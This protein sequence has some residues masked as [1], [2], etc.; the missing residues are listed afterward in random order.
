MSL[1]LKVYHLIENEQSRS[2]ASRYLN[3]FLIVLIISNVTA[4]IFESEA[5]IRAAYGRFFFM[6]ELVSV[7]IFLVEYLARVWCCVE[8]PELKEHAT[9]RA[10]L[11]YVIKP[12]AIIDLMAI[13]PFL[14][15]LFFTVDL[16]YLRLFRVLRLMKLTH[17][18]KGFNIFMT[19]LQKE[20][21]S[22]A[23]AM[24]MMMFLIVIAASVM[25]A[26]E[27]K[28]QPEQFG[29][30]LHSLWWAVVTMTTVGYGDVT[31]LTTGGRIVATFIMIIGVGFVALPAGMLAGRFGEELR[32]RKLDLEVHIEQALADGQI[33]PSEYKTLQELADKLD[34][35]TED[36]EKNISL[37]KKE[38]LVGRCPLCGR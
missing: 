14:I 19:V 18:F 26:L 32:E 38:K 23:A 34:L 33:D 22:I 9:W 37:L 15:S 31:P 3:L 24:M 5:S 36:L 11:R 28:T 29:S 10:R 27:S 8:R 7:S 1:R 25:Y 30:I 16:R 35:S 6:F 21:K 13:L 2:N 20:A 12:I 17:Y 4:V